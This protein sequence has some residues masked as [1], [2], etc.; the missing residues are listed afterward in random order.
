MRDNPVVALII[1]VAPLSLL[2]IGGASSIYAPL[3]RQVVDVEH[4][5][6]GR[7]FI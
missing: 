7:E 5:L 3:Q 6:T 2:A 4:W 1:V